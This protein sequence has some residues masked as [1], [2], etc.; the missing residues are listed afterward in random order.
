MGPLPLKTAV[1]RLLFRLI[2]LLP[3]PLVRLLGGAIGWLMWVSNGRSAKTTKTNIELCFSDLSEPER[4]AL[5]KDSLIETGRSGLELI[6]VLMQPSNRSA[7][8]IV[9]V[10]NEDLFDRM[11]GQGKG[12][13]VLIPHLGNWEV[14]GVWC[15]QRNVGL[16][17]MYQPARQAWLDPVIRE[18]REDKGSE[19]FPTD[20]GGVR[21]LLKELKG[22][23]AVALLPDQEPEEE[24]GVFAPF[25]GEPALTMTLAQ[26]LAKRTGCAVIMCSARRVPDGWEIDCDALEGDIATDDLVES[27]TAMNA[28][29]EK[30]VRKT[31]AQYQWEYKR[32]KKRVDGGPKRYPF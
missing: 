27:A 19:V 11:W 18:A 3:L 20:I 12:V 2:A 15:G 28:A 8:R 5:V 17:A 7:N 23:A 30:V 16:Q 14:I 32:F 13:L 9:R 22:G 31:P 26:K 1:A 24:G 10:N 25:F 6:K 4:A 21:S 29:L